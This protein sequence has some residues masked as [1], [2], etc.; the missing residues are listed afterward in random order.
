MTKYLFS[1]PPFRVA[2]KE[3][4]EAFEIR[5]A[6]SVAGD[7]PKSPFQCT[8]KLS[9]GVRKQ[10]P[11]LKDLRYDRRMIDYIRMIRSGLIELALSE[12]GIPDRYLRIT[13]RLIRA[14]A[15]CYADSF[16]VSELPAL[17]V[18]DVFAAHSH[19]VTTLTM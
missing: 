7:T 18:L 15:R 8:D 19:I 5:L 12:C 10:Y 9:E 11:G 6:S 14:V 3:L 2:N 13:L 16:L 1:I 4:I 17:K